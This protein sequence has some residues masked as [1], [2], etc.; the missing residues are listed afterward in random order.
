M[1]LKITS[2]C[3]NCWACIDVCPQ[4]AIVEASPHFVI[5]AEQCNECL[6]V[7]DDPQCASICPIE[8]AIVDSLGAYLNPPGSLTGIPLARLIDFGLWHGAD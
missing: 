2:A 3:R 8:A 7:H 1:A 4:Q 5:K 6:G